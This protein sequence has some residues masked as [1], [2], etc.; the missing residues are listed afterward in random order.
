MKSKQHKDVDFAVIDA[1][2][3]ERIFKTASEAAGFA[4]ALAVA[5]GRSHN[6]D[7]LIHS[8]EAARWV[9]GDDAVAHYKQD[10][11]ASVDERIVVRAESIGRVR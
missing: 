10:P 5:D 6:I 7:V 4:V 2:D 9:G 3:N 8:L 11:D 1:S